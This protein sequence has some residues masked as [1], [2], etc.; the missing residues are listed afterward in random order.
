MIKD[1][2]F[3]LWVIIFALAVSYLKLYMKL[4][5]SENRLFD[6]KKSLIDFF[7]END[8]EKKTVLFCRVYTAEHDL[9]SRNNSL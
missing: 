1:K 5:V 4:Q 7:E 2:T 6:L 9:E 8:L 3:I